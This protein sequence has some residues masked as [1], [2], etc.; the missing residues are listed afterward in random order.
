MKCSNADTI[1]KVHRCAPSVTVLGPGVRAVIW[2]Q[3]CTHQCAGCISPDTWDQTCGTPVS[4]GKM[5]SWVLALPT[6]EGITISGGEPML[7]AGTLV[8]LIDNIRSSRE[9]GVVCY[10]GFVLEELQAVA[11]PSQLDLLGRID[12]LVDGPYVESLHGDLLWRGSANQRLLPLTDRY[13]KLI[14]ELD[15]EEDRSAGLQ[16]FGVHGGSVP[17]YAG[18]PSTRRFRESF[19]AQMSTRGVV[20]T[21]ETEETNERES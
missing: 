3:G 9:V 17:W 1:L 13:A 18:I 10:T 12:L 7:Q 19:E 4:V 15:P 6:I 21:G 5:A 11:T 8:D 16:F 20:L 14:A 2:V